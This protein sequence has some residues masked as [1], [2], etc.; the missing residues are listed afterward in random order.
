M[1]SVLPEPSGNKQLKTSDSSWPVPGE[2]FLPAIL[3]GSHRIFLF[4]V[5]LYAFTIPNPTEL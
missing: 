1:K 3:P 2:P 5:E 4:S